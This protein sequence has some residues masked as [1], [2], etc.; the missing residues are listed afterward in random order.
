[1]KKR[2]LYIFI[3]NILGGV[4]LILF[5][6]YGP[7]PDTNSALWGAGCG[8]I[9]ASLV[10]LFRYFYWSRPENAPRYEEKVAEQQLNLHDERKTMIREKAGRQAFIYSFYAQ[11]V[12][13]VVLTVTKLITPY[14][15]IIFMIF[16]F[17]QLYGS[18]F[19]QRRLE[20]EL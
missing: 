13:Y 6:L 8:V 18:R 20:S 14:A 1:M 5:D 4:S 16:W 2:N 3:I 11:I 9:G 12:L 10:H 15:S 7:L 17:V 19:L